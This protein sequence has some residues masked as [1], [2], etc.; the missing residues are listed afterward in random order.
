MVFVLEIDETKLSKKFPEVNFGDVDYRDCPNEGLLDMLARACHIGKPRY[1]FLLQQGVF[2]A[3]YFTKH[4]CWSYEEERRLIA[5]DKL[6][7]IVNGVM[8]LDFPV[9]Y[10]NSIIVGHSADEKIKDMVHR[11]AIDI[12]ADFLEMKIGKTTAIPYYVNSEK[13]CLL[14]HSNVV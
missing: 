7:K 6:V 9:E 13:L 14:G 12:D 8:L 10:I 5:N 4:S 2:S 3:A 1:H 11:L